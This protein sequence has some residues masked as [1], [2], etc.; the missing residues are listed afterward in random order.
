M[1]DR[2]GRD[3]RGLGNALPVTS[4]NSF[5]SETGKLVQAGEGDS[6]KT[7]AAT[8]AEPNLLDLEEL[9]ISEPSPAATGPSSMPQNGFSSQ[10]S[11]AGM[12]RKGAAPYP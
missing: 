8:A 7:A 5:L 4:V 3:E 11:P 10:P 2:D 12:F 6:A 1:T 9:T